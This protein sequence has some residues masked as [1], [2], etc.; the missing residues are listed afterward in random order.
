[1]KQVLR[2]KKEKGITL[3]ALVITIIV[4]LI[5]AGVT[6]AALT[7]DNGILAK[8]QQAINEYNKGSSDEQIKL[9]T[10]EQWM[11]YYETGEEID[12]NEIINL[13]GI[14]EITL[15]N[16]EETLDC[17][18]ENN[19]ELYREKIKLYS[20]TREIEILESRKIAELE[21]IAIPIYLMLM[22]NQD[23]IQIIGEIDENNVRVMYNNNLYIITREENEEGMTVKISKDT[24]EIVEPDDINDWVY[25]IEDNNTVTILGYR[26]D[27][28]EIV[29]PNYINSMP[30]IRLEPD[31]QPGGNY[32]EGFNYSFWNPEDA[33]GKGYSYMN[34]KIKK[35]TVSE[36][37]QELGAELFVGTWGVNEI[38][39]PSTL[40]KI[41]KNAL[42]WM[43][44]EEPCTINI[45]KSVIEME[46]N[47]TGNSS[48]PQ[49]YSRNLI[50]NIEA[51]EIPETWDSEWNILG[52]DKVQVN[53][54][55]K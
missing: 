53:L 4:L 14:Y 29:I 2:R 37:I 35:I 6:I 34:F 38:K 1:M 15:L 9:S 8:A 51:E 7:G 55:V 16:N 54:G 40:I 33:E 26:G 10:M 23:E 31:Y 45:P 30:V 21:E 17:I 3:I 19:G 27:D 12:F 22:E 11:N 18:R 20:E 32:G 49:L 5:L 43:R 13:K 44:P 50:I 42:A 46:K 36:G 48:P 24:M 47:V 41:E 28:T 52:E 39:L 25:R